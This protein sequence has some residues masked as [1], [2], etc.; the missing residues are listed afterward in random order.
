MIFVVTLYTLKNFVEF[1]QRRNHNQ[2]AP[3]IPLHQLPSIAQCLFLVQDLFPNASADFDETL[4]ALRAYPKEGF[5]T[6]GTSGYSPVWILEP[7]MYIVNV[8]MSEYVRISV[9][10]KMSGF[11]FTVKCPDFCSIISYLIPK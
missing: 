7:K 9:H 2:I 10:C 3:A 8:R 5:S 1:I 11:L 4:H 6:I